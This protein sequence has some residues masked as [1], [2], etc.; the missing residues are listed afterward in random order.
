MNFCVT[1][2]SHY[3]CSNFLTTRSQFKNKICTD[4]RIFQTIIFSGFWGS[5]IT[6]GSRKVP[7]Q[8]YPT[9]FIIH[10][11]EHLLGHRWFR[12]HN[13]TGSDVGEFQRPDFWF[14]L[15]ATAGFRRWKLSLFGISKL[16][17]SSHPRL[18]SSK[19]HP[20]A[21]CAP[22]WSYRDRSDQI[23]FRSYGDLITWKYFLKIAEY[24]IQMVVVVAVFHH[25]RANVHSGWA[26]A[27]QEQHHA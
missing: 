17:K 21:P 11:T 8:K 6:E 10:D 13:F 26:D 7:R 3:V 25:H 5:K 2:S 22:G 12:Y 27:H 9:F 24:R 14:L 16:A 1:K 20:S 4:I 23:L 15:F 18:V 19:T